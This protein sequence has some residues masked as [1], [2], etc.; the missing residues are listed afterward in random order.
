[1][2]GFERMSK[3]LGRADEGSAQ[4]IDLVEAQARRQLK[5]DEEMRL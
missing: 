5:A 3:G 2:Y 4:V 1:M